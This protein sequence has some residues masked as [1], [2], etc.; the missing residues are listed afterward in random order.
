MLIRNQL[1][2]L[3][4]LLA[5]CSPFQV[6]KTETPALPE[7]YLN[8]PPDQG[9]MLADRWWEG[10]HDPKLN[11]LQLQLFN[12]NLDLRQA[13]YRLQQLEAQQR[14]SETSLWPTLNLSGSLSREQTPA[15]GGEVTGTNQRISLAAGYEI[16]LW[17]R[18]KNRNEAAQLRQLAGRTEVQT[19]LLSLSAQLSDLYFLAVEQRAQL[20]FGQQQV[21]NYRQLVEILASRYRAGLA[22]AGEVYRAQQD[23]AMAEA[24][25]PNYRAA[26]QQAENTIALLLGQPP[27]APLTDITSLPQLDSII[28]AGLPASLLTRR[29]DIA[30]AL[31]QVQ[32]AD[33]ELAAALAERLPTVNL[34]AALGHSVTQAA[35][36]SIEGTFWSLALGLTQPVFDAGRRQAEADRQQAVREE[37]LVGYQKAILTAI[38]E[39]ETALSSE[40]NSARRQELLEQQWQANQRELLLARDNFRSGLI[41]SSSLLASELRFLDVNSQLITNRRQWLSHRISLARALGGSWMEEELDSR[42]KNLSRQQDRQ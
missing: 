3:L 7:K 2:C 35:S 39:V 36:G 12:D 10:F 32:A 31:L 1:A 4:L 19:L 40:R 17:N 41:E 27:Q 6:V 26:L 9:N 22:S 25:L 34:T 28:D 11:R 29:P 21:E 23:L 8:A 24:R 30:A 16:D 20:Q 14:S 15:P 5:A 37:Q 33:H 18:L 42:M 13:L 38:K